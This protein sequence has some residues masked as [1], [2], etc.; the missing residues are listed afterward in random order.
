MFMSNL[1]LVL[2]AKGERQAAEALHRKAVAIAETA[3]GKD[4]PHAR[5]VRRNLESLV[6]PS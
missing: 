3:L 6:G 5:I 2:Q 4:H 1:V